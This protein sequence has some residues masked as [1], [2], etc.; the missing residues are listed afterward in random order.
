VP[1][2]DRG[3]L[4]PL[5]IAHGLGSNLLLFRGLAESLGSNQPVYGVQLAAPENARL[6]ELRLEAFAARSVEEICAV[7]PVGPYYLAGHSLGGLLALEIAT[8]LRRL[9]KEVGLLVLLD[10]ELRTPWRK[11]NAP[12]SDSMS[13]KDVWL[14]WRKKVDRLFASGMVITTWRKFVYTKLMLKIWVLRQT[15][16]EGT[17]YPQ[18]F[19]TDPYIALL[20]DQYRPQPMDQDAV[21]F[22]AEDE[23]P[24]E[25][26]GREWSQLLGGHLE[27]RK[28]PGS[29][30][31]IFTSPNVSVLAD[32]IAGRLSLSSRTSNLQPVS[33]RNGS[34]PPMIHPTLEYHGG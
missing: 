7:D 9:G 11:E 5:F 17:F 26:V 28:V 20:A 14:R 23:L 32:E 19:G 1:I 3:S 16:R 15:H 18:V 13:L 34:R 31:T 27:V 10:C 25:S 4:P 2:R 12:V 8:Q 30:Q 29:H 22:V 33:R 21:L 24:P 6:E